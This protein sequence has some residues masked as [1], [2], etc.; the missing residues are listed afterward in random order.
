M[1]TYNMSDFPK[2]LHEE[3][4][5]T[6]GKIKDYEA[7][8]RPVSPDSAIGRVSRMDAINNRSVVMAALNKA[9]EK[10]KKLKSME[11]R[12]NTKGF[13]VCIKCKKVIPLERLFLVPESSFCVKCA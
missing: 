5:K 10:L 3:V 9:K 7:L 2:K 11:T 8:C 13:G 6:L 4:E 12:I 1:K